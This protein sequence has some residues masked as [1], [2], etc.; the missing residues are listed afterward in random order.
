MNVSKEEAVRRLNCIR[1]HLGRKMFG[2]HWR[3][4]IVF[5]LFQHGSKDADDQHFHAVVG[6]LA[7][8]DWSDDQ[9]ADAIK[10]IEEARH[11]RRSADRLWE[12][13]A[14]VD[15]NWKKGNRYHSYVGRYAIKRHDEWY[16]I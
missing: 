13:M 10:Q 11:C 3:G 1:R 15:W 12:K 8:H 7:D 5:A 4:K 9:I 14:H 2:N 6:F 16:I